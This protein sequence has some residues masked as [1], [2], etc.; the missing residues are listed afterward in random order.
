MLFA[1]LRTQGL[2]TAPFP[3][4]LEGPGSYWLLWADESPECHF[5]RWMKSQFDI[6]TATRS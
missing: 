4:M 2:L 3:W 1:D 5:V 6:G